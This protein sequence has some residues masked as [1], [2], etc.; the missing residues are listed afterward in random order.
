MCKLLEDLKKEELND[1]QK[2]KIDY[3]EES[4]LEEETKAFYWKILNK[5]INQFELDKNKDL[6]DFTEMEIKDILRSLP[7]INPNV[8][9]VTFSI[10]TRYIDWAYNRKFNYTG[11]PCYNIEINDIIEAN[12]RIKSAYVIMDDFWDVMEEIECSD[13]DKMILVLLRYG[14]NAKQIPNVKWD[15]IDKE[16]KTMT[17]Y[18]DGEPSV[19]PIDEEF[20][21]YLDKCKLC[22]MYYKNYLVEYIDKGYVIKVTNHTHPNLN[23]ITNTSVTNRVAVIR[24]N[25]NINI[26]ILDLTLSRK[27]DLGIELWRKNDKKLNYKQLES[28]M[29]L[30]DKNITIIKK[31]NFK[32]TFELITGIEVKLMR[33]RKK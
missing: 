25:N 21:T 18:V 7:S 2:N 19:L 24:R 31:H 8:I 26:K 16:K 27:I 17:I 11:N 5:K 10:M 30:F 32:R 29:E 6:Y 14:V 28:V 33:N 4:V 20:I 15:D 12:T 9:K 23:K 3:L 1:F 13:V 22:S